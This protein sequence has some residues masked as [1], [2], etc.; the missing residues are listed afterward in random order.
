MTLQ[1]DRLAL[2]LLATAQAQKEMTHN[3]ALALLDAIVQPVVAAVSPA[4]VPTAPVPGQGWIVGLSPTGAWS[5]HAGALAVWTSGGWRFVAPFEG[6]VVWSAADA[7]PFRRTA[8]GWIGGALTGRTLTLDGL[9]VIGARLG[10]IAGPVGG[11]VIDSE[12]RSSV[13]A[14]LAALRTHGLIAI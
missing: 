6:M 7:M 9:Q 5:G 3:E 13:L 12:A 8:A 14:I 1:T 10:A 2:P 4:S 11:A